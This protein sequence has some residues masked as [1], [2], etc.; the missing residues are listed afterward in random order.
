[1]MTV[2]QDATS[3]KWYRV[4]RDGRRLH[5]PYLTEAGALGGVREYLVVR[6]DVT[7]LTDDEIACLEIEA[8]VQAERSKGD[9]MG[10]ALGGGHP[11]VDV[12]SYVARDPI[13]TDAIDRAIA[14]ASTAINAGP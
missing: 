3:G 2:E 1:M 13:E 6:Y 10:G 4:G 9:G 8:A 12:G 11:G 14:R 5:G 7:G